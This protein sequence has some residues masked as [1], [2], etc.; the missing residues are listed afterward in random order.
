MFFFSG[1]NRPL[2]IALTLGLSVKIL[3]GTH[4]VLLQIEYINIIGCVTSIQAHM[5]F[6]WLLCWLLSWLVGWLVGLLLGK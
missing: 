6:G 1:A 4:D 2:Q 3:A 5:C